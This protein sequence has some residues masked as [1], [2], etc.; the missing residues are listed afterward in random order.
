MT[1]FR[2]E[3]DDPMGEWE[4]NLPCV[5]SSWE[6]RRGLMAWRGVERADLASSPHEPF[7]ADKATI[8]MA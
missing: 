8:D 3:V 2:P 5:L 6:T 4:L 1:F 7:R